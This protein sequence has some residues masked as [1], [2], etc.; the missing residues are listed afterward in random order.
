MRVCAKY[1]FSWLYLYF[2]IIK[3]FYFYSLIIAAQTVVNKDIDTPIQFISENPSYILASAKSP[4]SHTFLRCDV[5]VNIEDSL[6]FDLSKREFYENID[7]KDD[8]DDEDDDDDNQHENDP[9]KVRQGYQQQLEKQKKKHARPII[10]RENF[11]SNDINE[12]KPTSNSDASDEVEYAHVTRSKRQ[13]T[14][15]KIISFEWLRN[16][17]SFISINDSNSEIS[18]DGYIL[19]PNGTLKFQVTNLTSGVYR[20]HAKY[21]DQRKKF[22]IGPIRSTSTT[23]EIACEYI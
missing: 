7:D 2:I 1:A 10:Q 8:D 22:E 14:H 13:A 17:N 23:I 20:C 9:E 12:H 15:E 21:I 5:A 19:F 11:S 16:D 18:R 3:T 6:R 4:I